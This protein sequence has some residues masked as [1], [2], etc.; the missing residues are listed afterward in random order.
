[1]KYQTVAVFSALIL[2]IA[3]CDNSNTARGASADVTIKP[4]SGTVAVLNANSLKLSSST[5]KV[6]YNVTVTLA[7]NDAVLTPA[8]G[9]TPTFNTS[10]GRWKLVG[11]SY[12]TSVAAATAPPP[13]DTTPTPPPDTTPT[14]PPPTGSSNE[15][16]GMT[17]ISS[18]P[19]NALHELGWDEPTN[20][21]PLKNV[22]II[23]DATAP[24]SP[25]NALRF[26]YWAGSSG[27]GAPWDADSPPFKY[28]TVYVSNWTRVSTNW[29][30]HPGSLINK[31][32]YL[33]TTTD[34]P[35]I[36]IVL[37]GGNSNPLVPF[38]EGQN[39]VSGGQGSADPQNP[40][41]GP[42]LGVSS[43]KTQVVRGQWFNVE[44]LAQMNT[45]GNADGFIDLWLN[46]VKIT[47]VANVKFQNT[48]PYWRSL[49]HAP[50]WGGGGG[51]V[52]NTM[53]MDFD[54]LYV[55]GK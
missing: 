30:G 46:G 2:G 13:P 48:P 12:S 31:M 39:I 17:V 50:V 22:T 47:H 36:V 7:G 35:S 10:N 24:K 41:W 20:G 18:R 25:T 1:M 54:H 42:N 11:G 9:L 51:T 6:S 19:F 38:I 4:A 33:Y 55:S 44:V 3:A 27:G 37:H 45:Q 52:A 49:H 23:T 21:Q 14:Q 15:P 53:Y 5:G 29:Q 43:T 28:R 40:D 34:V 26:I 8:S 16:A 32:Y